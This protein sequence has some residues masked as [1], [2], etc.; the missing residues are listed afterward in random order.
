MASEDH[1]TE[2]MTETVEADC[3][4][5]QEAY[6]NMASR[7]HHISKDTDSHPTAGSFE[8]SSNRAPTFCAAEL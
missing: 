5:I 1:S 4:W 8:A 3:H 6:G 7:D 2:K